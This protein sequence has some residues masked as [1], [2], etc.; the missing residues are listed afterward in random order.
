VIPTASFALNRIACPGLG[1]EDFFRLARE[2]GLAKVELRNDLAGA[3]VTDGLSPARAASLA[4][5]E[6]VAII[7]I[8]ALQKF[9]GKAVAGRVASDLQRLLEL[10]STLRC[11][12]IVLCPNNDP[13]DVRDAA[14]RRSETVEALAALGRLFAGRGVLGC[15]E[16]LGFAESSL[17]SVSAAAAAVKE[18]GQ[19][20]YRILHDTFHHYLG[21]DGSTD[22][23][24]GCDVRSIGL[25]HASGVETQLAKELIRDEH[26]VLVSAADLTGCRE[27]VR[28]LVELGYDGDI[29]FEP[30]SPAVKG[31]GRSQLVEAL[32]RS[33]AYLRG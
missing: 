26:R 13:A 7:S 16:P 18:S 23:G 14:T 6:G 28:R 11:P 32:R 4:R 24:A 17:A 10:A 29:S 2:A 15:V 9:N 1:L 5:N 12:A 8:N 22:A 31:L 19:S 33:L 21:P 27:Q 3:R 25:V 20:C 30:F